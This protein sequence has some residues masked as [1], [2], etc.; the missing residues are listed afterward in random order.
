VGVGLAGD[1]SSRHIAVPTLVGISRGVTIMETGKLGLVAAGR[2]GGALGRG[3]GAQRRLLAVHAPNTPDL[4]DN[5]RMARRLA[6]LGAC[7]YATT[8]RISLL[9]R[10]RTRGKWVGTVAA[11]PSAN[12]ASCF[13][14][15]SPGPVPRC[16]D[17]APAMADLDFTSRYPACHSRSVPW[18][19]EQLPQ[20]TMLVAS[21]G[22]WLIDLDGTAGLGP[23]RLVRGVNLLGNEFYKGCN[24]ARCAAGCPASD[25]VLGVACTR[26]CSTTC[27]GCAGF[28]ATMRVSLSTMSGHRGWSWHGGCLGWALLYL[29]RGR[30]QAGG[31]FLRAPIIG[32]G[33][34]A[35]VRV[36]MPAADSPARGNIRARLQHHAATAGFMFRQT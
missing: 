21:Q 7:Q 4:P 32:P 5:P 3:G 17:I 26:W 19:R 6:R 15:A 9:C 22:R 30:A 11:S 35:A 33:G 10:R 31:A 34:A 23:H 1:S 18:L 25:R 20:A 28:R 12:C 13:A 2:G 8:K 27:G 36:A 24:R 29:T 16:G 14:N